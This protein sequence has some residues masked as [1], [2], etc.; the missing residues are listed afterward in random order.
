V[1]NAHP[2]EW[3]PG[4]WWNSWKKSPRVMAKSLILLSWNL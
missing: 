3:E 2:A 1:V 4:I